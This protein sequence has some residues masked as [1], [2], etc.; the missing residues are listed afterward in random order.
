RCGRWRSSSR[1]SPCGAAST[2]ERWGTSTIMATSTWPSP[3][4]RSC[5][6]TA[7]RTGESEPASSP[8]RIPR[9]NGTRRSTR[10]ARCGSRCSAPSAACGEETASVIG[11]IDN[12]DSFTYNLVQYL[13]SLG[14][15]LE[16]WR[17]DAVT[18]DAMRGKELDGL[19]ISPGPGVPKDAG[20]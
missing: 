8:T 4:A 10:G 13:G 20:I 2:P 1:S 12:Y 11:V 3:S 19:V 16:V 18:V 9:T 5:T 6:R 14:A 15:T 17:N 7:R